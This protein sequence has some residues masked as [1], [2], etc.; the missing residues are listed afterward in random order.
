MNYFQ[1]L[2]YRSK[3]AIKTIFVRVLMKKGYPSLVFSTLYKFTE[4]VAIFFDNDCHYYICIHP[5]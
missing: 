3:E 4:V 2:Q 5:V 1:M